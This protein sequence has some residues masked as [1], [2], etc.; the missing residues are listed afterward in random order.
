[1]AKVWDKGTTGGTRE[2]G[3]GAVVRVIL[4]GTQTVVT[5]GVN[6]SKVLLSVVLHLQNIKTSATFA[7]FALFFLLPKHITRHIPAW[8][9]GGGF[10][11]F[12]FFFTTRLF[13]DLVSG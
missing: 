3:S 1:M 9:S 11:F 2:V 4:I 12:F 8:R 7:F 13:Y 5:G 6:S 10:C